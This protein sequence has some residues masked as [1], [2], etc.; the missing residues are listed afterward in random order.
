[1]IGAL[2]IAAAVSLW[3]MRDSE[4]PNAFRFS[5]RMPDISLPEVVMPELDL[6]GRAPEAAQAPADPPDVTASVA[7]PIAPFGSGVGPIVQ[8]VPFETCLA[9]VSEIGSSAGQEP[10]VLEDSAARRVWRYKFQDGD[11]RMTCSRADN[12]LTI[13]PRG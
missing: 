1:V 12:T 6:R 3:A 9:M 8:P 2:A 13:E 4:W 7:E 10:I 11:I 5:W